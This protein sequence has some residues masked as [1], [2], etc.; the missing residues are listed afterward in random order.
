MRTCVFGLLVVT[1][2]IAAASGCS[3]KSSGPDFYGVPTATATFVTTYTGPQHI[4]L[5]EF[6]SSD[7]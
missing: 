2:T 5:V 6:T 7:G 4:A 3:S 1:L